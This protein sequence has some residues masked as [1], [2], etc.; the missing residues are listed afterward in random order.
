MGNIPLMPA[1]QF[2]R[3]GDA[4]VILVDNPPVNALSTPVRASLIAA[5]AELAADPSVVCG[6][7]AATGRGFIA[8]A[9]IRE[10]ARAPEPPILP[11]V[12]DA[13]ALCPKPLVAALKAPR[14]AGVSRSR[15]RAAAAWRLG[16]RRS[17]SRR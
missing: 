3:R 15:W 14:S 12:I 7:I 10:M 11:E 8:G 17:A 9:D 2:I 5:L 6:V 16:R 4:G 1:V 13:I